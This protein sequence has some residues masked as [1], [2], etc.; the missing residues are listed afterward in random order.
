MIDG[1]PVVKLPPRELS[2][3]KQQFSKQEQTFYAELQK[4]SAAKFKVC[5]AFRTSVTDDPGQIV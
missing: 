3:V 5:P 1:E 4:E 2:L